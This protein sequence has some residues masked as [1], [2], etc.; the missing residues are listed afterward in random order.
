MYLSRA[1]FL[2]LFRKE[3]DERTDGAQNIFFLFANIVRK[4]EK[5]ELASSSLNKQT[6]QPRLR[7][8]E[9]KKKEN[10]MFYKMIRYCLS[11]NHFT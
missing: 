7:V 9:A 8:R 3:R 11:H 6:E 1:F 4:G 5:G 10:L 2:R